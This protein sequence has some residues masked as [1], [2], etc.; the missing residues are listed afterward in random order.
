MT[1]KEIT[2]LLLLLLPVLGL[3]YCLRCDLNGYDTSIKYVVC[4]GGIV[5]MFVL[6]IFSVAFCIRLYKS[7]LATEEHIARMAVETAHRRDLVDQVLTHFHAHTWRVNDNTVV[8]SRTLAK[9]LGSDTREI[10]FGLF[11][12]G[13]DKESAEKLIEFLKIKTPGDY[14]IQIY[15]DLQGLGNH[16]YELH[17]KNVVTKQGLERYGVTVMIDELKQ[18]EEHTLNVHR[19]LLNAEQC[20]HFISMMN[21]EIRT[22]LNSIVGFSQMLSS[23]DLALPEEDVEQIGNSIIES[24]ESLLKLIG[25]ILLLTHM[26]NSNINVNLQDSNVADNL[27]E[28]CVF[29]ESLRKEKNIKVVVEH[30]PSEAW[31]H[32]DHQFMVTIV[33]NLSS[34]AIK[35]SKPNSTIYLGWKVEGDEVVVYVRDEGIGISPEDQKRIFERFFKADPFTPGV[36]LGLSVSKEFADRMHGRIEVESELGKGSTFS[37]H[38]KRI[39]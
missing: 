4:I 28:G 35:F 9:L 10:K 17:M 36:G 34:N 3:W 18:R 22:P 32:I 8:V 30:G 24:S 15:G 33:D 13:L 7:K 25:N 14:H 27:C 1:K 5:L 26:D 29:Y 37:V 2:Y 6:A 19:R 39:R 20:E 11:L 38:L 31:V 16:W 21:H 23:P 12:D